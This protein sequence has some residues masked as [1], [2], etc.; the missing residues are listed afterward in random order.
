MDVR[1]AFGLKQVIFLLFLA[2]LLV[3]GLGLGAFLLGQQNALRLVNRT[4]QPPVASAQAQ[5]VVTDPAVQPTLPRAMTATPRPTATQEI[6]ITDAQA[7]ELAQQQ[8]SQANLGIP[9]QIGSVFFTPGKANLTGTVDYLGYSGDFLITGTPYVD[10]G[11]LRVKVDSFTIGGQSLP[12]VVY[13]DL[14][15]EINGLFDQIFT[16]Y[17]IQSISVEAGQMRLTVIPW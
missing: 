11:R 10:A 9:I 12:G 2:V 1:V 16:G 7:T 8:A 13:A 15:K 5:I 6:V 4:A 14:E 17:E 3:A